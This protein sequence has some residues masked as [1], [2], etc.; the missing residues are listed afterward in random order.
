MLNGPILYLIRCAP[1][2]SEVTAT[3]LPSGAA[4]AGGAT[5]ASSAS[6][7][8]SAHP[9]RFRAAAMAANLSYLRPRCRL[10]RESSRPIRD[11]ATSTRP[12]ALS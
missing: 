10:M 4:I 11:S 3:A 8:M 6:V 5:T 7:A 9:A 1:L 12:R 2:A